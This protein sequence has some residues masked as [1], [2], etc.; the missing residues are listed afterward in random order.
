MLWSGC[1]RWLRRRPP[2]RLLAAFTD[3]H[4]LALALFAHGFLLTRVELPG[5]SSCGDSPQKLRFRQQALELQPEPQPATCGPIDTAT[6]A[7]NA[8]TLQSLRTRP[9]QQNRAGNAA[10]STPAPD[11]SGQANDLPVSCPA[12]GGTPN[13]AAWKLQQQLP[14]CL[15]PALP[16]RTYLG[17]PGNRFR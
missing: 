4:L 9:Q 15:G 16:N 1:S 12:P 5:R 10:T 17:S 13:S 2:W 11:R 8:P 14:G 3:L 6:V 7:V